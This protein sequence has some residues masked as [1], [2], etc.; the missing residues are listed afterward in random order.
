[1][2]NSTA[3]FARPHFRVQNYV[4]PENPWERYH[5]EMIAWEE[6]EEVAFLE[7]RMG[8]DLW[9]GSGVPP[10]KPPKP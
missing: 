4:P 9:P 7:S 2:S 1:M 5:R 6:A 10:P 8:I 3:I